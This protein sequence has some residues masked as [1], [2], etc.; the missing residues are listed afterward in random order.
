MPRHRLSARILVVLATLAAFLAIL[1]IWANRQLLNTDNW[2]TTSTQLLERPVIRTQVAGFLVDQLYANVDVAGELS[3]ALPPQARALAG[4]AASGLRELADRAAVEALQRPRVQALWANAN[5]EAH[6]QLLRVLDGGG[7]NVSTDNGVV[8]L[9][10]DTLLGNLEQRTGVGGRLAARLP[11]GAADITL[12]RSDQLATAQ[13][14]LQLLRRLPYILVILSL[15]LFAGALAISPGWR[16]E[17]LRAYGAGFVI[18]G[19]AALITQ[20]LAGDA[21][22]NAL[23]TTAA[24]KPSISAGWQ[25]S[26]TPLVQ[27]AQ[28]AIGYGIAMIVAAWLGGPTAAAVTT[29][30]SLA[31]YARRPAVAYGVLAAFVLVL[32]WWGPTPA[33]RNPALAFVLI[34]LLVAATEVFRREIAREHPDAESREGGLGR[35]VRSAV[36]RVRG[37]ASSGPQVA[38]VAEHAPEPAAAHDQ[39]GDLERLSRL[40]QS[41]ALDANEFAAQKRALLAGHAAA[42]NGGHTS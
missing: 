41:G 10:L 35:A 26:T 16:R 13:D 2:T 20:S 4:P 15:A 23:A 12:L 27:A 25:V 40:H 22:A 34:L 24:V 36:D 14:G 6:K 1:A 37:H 30:R 28:A 18:A 17:A 7:P 8:V 39:L 9:H 33:T 32:L 31:P 42:P 38:V 11:A 21:L 3:S 29:R 19:A 5:R